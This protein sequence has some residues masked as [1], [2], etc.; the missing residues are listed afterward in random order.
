MIPNRSKAELTHYGRKSGKPYKVKIWYVVIDG[1]LWVGT[2]DPTRNWVRNV[3]A[4]G[5]AKIDFGQGPVA[6]RGEWVDDPTAVDSF[7][8]AV[9]AKYP[10]A[11]R[12]VSLMARGGVQ[13]ACRMTPAG[14]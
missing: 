13:A 10:I 14:P 12:L 9:R 2:L 11:S 7:R 4:N 1:E 6:Y 3:A 8:A 5:S